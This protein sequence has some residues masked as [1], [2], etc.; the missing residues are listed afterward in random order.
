MHLQYIKSTKYILLY[1]L[2]V[3]FC[4]YN[5]IFGQNVSPIGEFN[6]K[7]TSPIIPNTIESTPLTKIDSNYKKVDTVQIISDDKDINHPIN[8]HA[9]DSIVYD[10]KNKWLYL[11]GKAYMKYGDLELESNRINFDWNTFTL[12]AIGKLDEN[13]EVIERAVFKDSNGQYE[14]DSMQYNFKTKKGRTFDVVTQQDDAFIYSEIVQKNELDEWYG[15]KTKFTTCSNKDHPHYY[16][17]TRKSKVVPDEVMV[18]GPINLVV[19]GVNTPLVLPFGIFPTKKNRK[20]GIIMPQYGAQANAGFFLSNLGFHWAVNDRLAL[21]FTTDIYTRGTFAFGVDA[22]YKVRYKYGGSIFFKYFRTMPD[23][24]LATTKGG[25]NSF[26]FLWNHQMDQKA[27]PHHSFTANVN[28]KTSKYNQNSLRTDDQLLQVQV[29]SNINYVRK[30]IGKPYTFSVSGTHNQ[31]LSNNS[32]YIKFPE[33]T[34]NVS[35]FTPFERK[36]KKGKRKFYEKIGITYSAKAK[37]QINTID[38]LLFTKKALDDIRFGIIQDLNISAPFSLGSFLTFQP[39]IKYKERWYFQKEQKTYFNDSMIIDGKLQYVKTL[40][41]IKYGFFGVRDFSVNVPL[42]TTITG[43]FNFKSK[44]FKAIRHIIKPSVTYSFSPDFSTPFWNYYDSYYDPD[45]N[46][47]IEYNKFQALSGVYGTPSRGM[48][49]KISYGLLNNFHMKLFSKKDT[50]N[51]IKKLPLIEQ[52]NISSYYDF[53]ADSL[54]MGPLSFSARST[55]LNRLLYW[56]V[57][58]NFSPYKLNKDNQVVNEF[59]FKEKKRLLRFVDADFNFGLSLA[60]K[61]KQTKSIE[62]VVGEIYEREYIKNNPQFFYDFNIPWSL[63]LNYNIKLR[64]GFY[65]KPDSTGISVNSVSINGHINI[66]PKWQVNL[67]TGFDFTQM[68]LVLTR[69]RVERD[70]HC[71][72]IAFDWTAYPLYRQTYS[73]DL[74]IKSAMLQELRLTKKQAPNILNANF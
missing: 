24:D 57:N 35:R 39:N 6:Q 43:I 73:I 13:K 49:N 67:S 18:T 16:F 11:Y 21:N 29:N 52:F 70:L 62:E 3:H 44:R 61:S 58:F 51:P 10:V 1:T 26:E 9:S 55:L 30:F 27:S 59:Y 4:I 46:K 2:V 68:D 48:S 50:A 28:G 33:L 63:N 45:K 31:N 65:E 34:F 56:Q 12:T 14:A 38:S 60:G 40:D 23:F 54:K 64:K 42:T 17:A 36:I 5:S 47:Y 7:I 19:S 41:S 15:Y 25:E 53:T 74:H 32:I 72:V 71:W 20:S 22:N 69:V 37:S 8:Y 66:T